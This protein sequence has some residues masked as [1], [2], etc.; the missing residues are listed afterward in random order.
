M[1]E[2]CRKALSFLKNMTVKQKI[3]SASV[4]AVILITA[5]LVPII[6][7]NTGKC[8]H[9]FDNACD[10]TCNECGETRE[11]GAHDYTAA[12][13]DTP[14]TCKNC[15]ATKGQNKEHTYDN[16]CDADCNEC[17]KTRVVQHNYSVLQNDETYHWY[18]CLVCERPDGENKTKHAYDNDC[19]TFCNTCGKERTTEHVP[20][21]DDGDCTTAVTC[22]LCGNVTTPAK[23]HD[24]SG[25]WEKDE[26]GHWHV[27][28]NDGCS[29][30]DT[31]AS[32]ISND[33]E[34]EPGAQ[35]CAE[36]GYE[37]T[38]VIPHIH[39]WG[40]VKY[41]WN[42][43]YTK[44]TATRACIKNEQHVETESA[45]ITSEITIAAS[46]VSNG[47][48]VYTATFTNE[49]FA[50]QTETVE[51]PA[52]TDDHEYGELTVEWNADY[53]DCVVSRYCSAGEHGD[54][55]LT[56]TIS[57]NN[58][59]KT[60]SVYDGSEDKIAVYVYKPKTSGNGYYLY[61]SEIKTT[62]YVNGSYGG[63]ISVKTYDEEGNVLSEGNKLI[64][65]GFAPDSD[66]SEFG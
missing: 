37:S 43:N 32:H 51:I 23:N 2:I 42:A 5:I 3:I 49:N 31:K 47:E 16:A 7:V 62:Y 19:D 59:V 58:G 63:N 14:K 53:S 48:I 27:C 40:T 12:D 18:V 38:V 36:C 25:A 46:C 33:V 39:E 30:T 11:V 44:C 50:T 24:F 52:S 35:L 21:S 6:I 10:T 65:E 29:V 54:E 15:G 61:S 34:N 56:K 17:N 41:E 57:D 22:S 20:N 66:D 55:E 8:D 60:V 26:S 4:V 1:K 45:T 28:K 13:C 9:V 64:F